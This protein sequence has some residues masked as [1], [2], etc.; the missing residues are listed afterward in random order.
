MKQ[1]LLKLVWIMP[2]LMYAQGPVKSRAFVLEEE[3][4]FKAPFLRASITDGKLYLKLPKPILNKDLLWTR[5]GS[6]EV[7]DTKQIEFRKEGQYI[8]MEQHRIWSETGV[9]IPLKAAP[10][11]DKLILGVFPI[12]EDDGKGY[13]IE[14]TDA[15]LGKGMAWEHRTTASMVPELSRV[16]EVRSRGG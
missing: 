1:L 6:S 7:Y 16:Q 8:Y 12:L 5:I 10:K 3:H 4:M 13:G 15:F 14:V 11:L 2:L 9:W